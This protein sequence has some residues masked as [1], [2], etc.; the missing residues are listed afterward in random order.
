M[1]AQSSTCAAAG[2]C[3]VNRARLQLLLL[4][5]LLS[6]AFVSRRL[7]FQWCERNWKPATTATRWKINSLQVLTC[8]RQILMHSRPLTAAPF[9][10]ERESSVI[11]TK[12]VFLI[13]KN[14]ITV[15]SFL[16]GGQGKYKLLLLRW[17]QQQQQLLPSSSRKKLSRRR[18]RTLCECGCGGK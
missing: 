7:L 14:K 9:I 15:K 18:R 1:I 10:L 11:L 8:D 13:K 5:L 3:L 4:L 12:D 16:K 6:A 17:K 2:G